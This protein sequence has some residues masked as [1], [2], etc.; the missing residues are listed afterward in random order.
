MSVGNSFSVIVYD[1]IFV[2]DKKKQESSNNVVF[3]PDE[4]FECWWNWVWP[5]RESHTR[6]GIATFVRRNIVLHLLLHN[7]FLDTLCESGWKLFC[8]LCIYSTQTSAVRMSEQ[9]CLLRVRLSQWG[10]WFQISEQFFFQVSCELFHCFPCRKWH[11]GGIDVL[12]VQRHSHGI[13]RNSNCV[14]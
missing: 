9:L 12:F 10:N 13:T 3:T 7:T 11:H 4:S 14:W 6:G 5:F 8:D 2:L 1:F